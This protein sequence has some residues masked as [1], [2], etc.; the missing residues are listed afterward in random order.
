MKWVEVDGTDYDRWPGQFHQLPFVRRDRSGIYIA[1]V[2]NFESRDGENL[3]ANSFTATGESAD[4][5]YK[6]LVRLLAETKERQDRE[7]RKQ[8]SAEIQAGE[9]GVWTA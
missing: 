8:L 9:D 6:S 4:E 3:R 5:A 2:R 7:L 1:W